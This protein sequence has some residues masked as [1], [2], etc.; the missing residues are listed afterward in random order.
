MHIWEL[1]QSLHLPLPLLQTPLVSAFPSFCVSLQRGC[2]CLTMSASG[3]EIN[4]VCWNA[5]FPI[6][7]Q[8]YNTVN[9]GRS[10][11]QIC[12]LLLKCLHISI[13]PSVEAVGA[14]CMAFVSSFIEGHPTLKS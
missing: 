6:F 1:S 13:P 14:D 8:S 5:Y 7:T 9:E 12:V 10:S 3:A 11:S 4:P 2:K